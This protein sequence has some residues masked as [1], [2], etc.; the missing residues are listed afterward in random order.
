MLMVA[1]LRHK[2]ATMRRAAG[3]NKIILKFDWGQRDRKTS[4]SKFALE[5]RNCFFRL[6]ANTDNTDEECNRIKSIKK[7]DLLS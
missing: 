1:E 7:P 2:V 4:R 3:S 6:Y 5:L